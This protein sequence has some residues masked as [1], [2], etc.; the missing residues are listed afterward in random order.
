MAR[1]RHNAK[2]QKPSVKHERVERREHKLELKAR[3][4]AESEAS[5]VQRAEELDTQHSEYVPSLSVLFRF[6]ALVRVSG[7]LLSPIQD[8]DEVYN[9]WEPLHFLQFG[10]GKQT[11]EYSPQ[12][13]LRSY[14]YLHIYDV[15]IR[16]MHLVI[17][18]RT[19]TQVF[20]ALRVCL[21]L[22]SALCE[23]VFVRSVAQH[24]DRRMAN[25]VWLGVFGMA[26]MFH[27]AH[28][29]LPTSFAMCLCMLGSAAAMAPPVSDVKR[30]MRNRAVPAIGAFALAVCAGWPYA[31]LVA[32]PFVLEEML[33]KGSGAS[34]RNWR[35]Q[36]LAM[37]VVVGV[38]ATVIALGAMAVVDSW[39][40]G[41]PVVAAWNQVAYNVLGQHNGSSTLYGTEPWYF[42]L[43][44][45][46]LNAN[47]VMI[48]ALCALPMWILYYVAL[49]QTSRTTAS[50]A[51]ERAMRQLLDG[52]FLLLFRL[53]PFYLVLVVFSLQAHKEERF[54]SI[55]Y[56]HL[57]F[58][59][60]AALSMASPL[61][62]WVCAQLGRRSR[63]GQSRTGFL[64]LAGAAC[65]GMLRM[66]ALVK[67]YGAPVRA[68]MELPT[69]NIT[70][71]LPLGPSIKGLRTEQPLHN[72]LDRVVCM[73]GA[74]Y[75]FPSS[76]WLPRGYHLQFVRELGGVDGHLPGDFV[77]A[78]AS[79]SVQKSTSVERPDFNARNEWEPSHA[80][81]LSQCDYA[82]DIEYPMR[83]EP[84]L[85]RSSEWQQVG[86]CH[87]VLDPV[88]TSV[89]AR[90]V[91]VPHMLA[92]MAGQRQEWGQMCVYERRNPIA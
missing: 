89:L 83:E 86:M 55:V 16:S 70:G 19:K 3:K 33:V 75:W 5:H 58:C 57:S 81:E 43:K 62:A 63:G 47:L 76:Y 29:V 88:N 72:D 42:Y 18:F 65:V 71:L 4:H 85:A 13:S 82:V 56:P 12:Y 90:M 11:W 80:I 34:T 41:R 22:M 15:L 49:K 21:A 24:V 20:Y 73:G 68:F 37:L 53:L 17:G 26:G 46:L 45:G 23:A 8:C 10:A 50:V 78:K 87:S 25:Y 67:Y 79:G 77:P 92:W 69:S 84:G 44:N 32:V 51:G 2:H 59:A 28:A 54:L 7:A 40:Y 39:Y 27:A 48:L 52:H 30:H 36:R 91:Y 61:R 74:W 66:T 64:V 1:Q 9:Y 60:S 31:G 14:A 6:L 35:A 38:G